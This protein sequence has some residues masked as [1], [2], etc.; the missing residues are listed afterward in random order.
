MR[1]GRTVRRT[2]VIISGCLASC[3]AIAG[4]PQKNLSDLDW[5]TGCWRNESNGIVSEEQWTRP[6]GGTMLGVS[7]TV[8]GERTLWFEFLQIRQ[9]GDSILYVARPSGQE[10]AAFP[11][12]AHDPASLTFENPS[13]D[14]PRRIVYT[15]VREDSISARIE[16][17]V[18]GKT[19]TEYFPMKR[20]SCEGAR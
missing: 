3:T 8:R 2:A 18:E 7:R 16:G 13:H 9:E 11:L 19:R 1:E 6:A 10:G 20:V 14:F 17:T 12:V 4:G 5:L 15:R